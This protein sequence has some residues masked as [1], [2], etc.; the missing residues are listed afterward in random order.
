MAG[1]H[2]KTELPGPKSRS[3]MARRTQAIPRGVYAGTPLFIRHAEGATLEDVD[4]NRFLDLG[5]GIGCMNVGHRNPRVVAALRAQID[6]FLHLCF[7]VTGY[8]SYIA[9]AEKLNQLTPGSFAKKTFLV[10]SGAE[11][12]ENAVKIARAFTGRPAVLS[13]EV[14]TIA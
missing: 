13:V 10:N 8:E 3:L 12:V 1:I 4:G 5:G 2:L 11:A 6:A 7:Q 9:V 14:Q